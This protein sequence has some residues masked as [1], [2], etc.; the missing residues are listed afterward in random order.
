MYESCIV[1]PIKT[2][3]QWLFGMSMGITENKNKDHILGLFAKIKS[4]VSLGNYIL[5][6]SRRTRVSILQQILI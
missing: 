1:S 2:T 4:M 6:G 5:G 3:E